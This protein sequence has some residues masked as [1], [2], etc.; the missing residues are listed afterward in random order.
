MSILS[1]ILT[2]KRKEIAERK[3]GTSVE[4]LREEA[5]AVTVRPDFRAA[6]DQ[7]GISVIAEVKHRSPSAGV[8]RSPFDP[9][10]I[11]RAYREAGA[12]A[13]SV[14]M[15]Q[16]FFGGGESHF[17]AVRE[18][19]DLPLL[20][21]EFVVDE[22]QVEHAAALGA[23][24]V[25]LIAAALAK[26]ELQFLQACCRAAGLTAL[27]EVH[28]Q[29]EAAVAAAVGADCVGVNN[30]NLKTFAVSLQT[31]L[32]VA[33]QLPPESLLISES[34]IRTPDDLIRLHRAGFQAVLV[35]QQL[36]EQP[37]PGAA[38]RDLTAGVA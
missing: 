33:G 14:L 19:V 31:S 7:S 17:R 22:W 23:S 1:D 37:D 6:L 16:K 36:L 2:A 21:K 35:G 27:V 8:I 34:G 3:N 15:D 28:N 10:A 4:S 29:A 25:L 5:A 20:Y 9:P 18:A 24:A 30:R 38:L 26:D 11:A 13:V 12:A 32:E